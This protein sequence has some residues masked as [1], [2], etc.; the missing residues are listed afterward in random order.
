MSF[1][2]YTNP[3]AMCAKYTTG[4]TGNVALKTIIDQ[5]KLEIMSPTG[6]I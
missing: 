6:S 2:K 3:H 1:I 5:L 4:V